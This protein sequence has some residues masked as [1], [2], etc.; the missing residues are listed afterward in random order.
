MAKGTDAISEDMGPTVS[1]PGSA[2]LVIIID[3]SPICKIDSALFQG[4]PQSLIQS[5]K[6][7]DPMIYI[8]SCEVSLDP[9]TYVLKRQVLHVP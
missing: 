1:L 2:L 4:P 9:E 3:I 7:R 5:D 8:R 6:D